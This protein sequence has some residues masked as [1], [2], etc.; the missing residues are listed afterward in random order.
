M[1]R[2]KKLN[3]IYTIPKDDV[4][5]YTSRGFK[6]LKVTKKEEPKKKDKK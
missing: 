3:Q 2:V 4:K 5:L 6:E 1:V